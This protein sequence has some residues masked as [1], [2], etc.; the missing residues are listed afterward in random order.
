MQAGSKHEVD[1]ALEKAPNRPRRRRSSSYS[2]VLTH[3]PAGQAW[4]TSGCTALHAS[5]TLDYS[6]ESLC[7]TSGGEW[8]RQTLLEPEVWCIF[9]NTAEHHALGNALTLAKME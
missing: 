4:P 2:R 1:I 5:I 8:S 6:D 7:T 3:L 9:D